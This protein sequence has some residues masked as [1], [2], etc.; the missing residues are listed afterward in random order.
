MSVSEQKTLYQSVYEGIQKWV[1]SGKYQENASIPSER[2]LCDHFKVSRLTVRRAIDELINDGILY[3]RP[4]SGTYVGAYNPREKFYTGKNRGKALRLVHLVIGYSEESFGDELISQVLMGVEK[5][6][7][8]CGFELSFASFDAQGKNDA[9]L[10]HSIDEL[11][12]DGVILQ[13]KITRDIALR[14][15]KIIP[16]VVV[17]NIFIP[18]KKI[19]KI[20]GINAVMANDFE[21]GLSAAEYFAEKGHTYVGM[22][23]TDPDTGHFGYERRELGF[24]AGIELAGLKTDKEN[25]F[26]Y[27]RPSVPLEELIEKVFTK[28]SRPTALFAYGDHLAVNTM[29]GLYEIGLRVPDDISI[30]GVNDLNIAKMAMPGLT[31]FKINWSQMGFEAVEK[32]SMIIHGKS[33]S[34][35]DLL[36]FDLIERESV[37][38]IVDQ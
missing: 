26:V 8:N 31:T 9:E 22:I 23:G 27:S 34:E 24:R 13:G 16:A 17:S 20:S 6:A 5:G 10:K 25:W 15:Q 38:K 21:I 1:N 28:K 37:K 4:G 14:I 30:V 36:D 19:K 3:R 2:N 35:I 18:Y 29:R 32:L 12:V 11:G 33:T 7:K